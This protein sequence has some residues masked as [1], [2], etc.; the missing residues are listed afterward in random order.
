VEVYQQDGVDLSLNIA[1]LNLKE[2]EWTPYGEKVEKILKEIWETGEVKNYQCLDLNWPA[3][4]KP[5]QNR[6]SVCCDQCHKFIGDEK[7]AWFSDRKKDLDF[8]S[9]GCHS[10]FR[11][12]NDLEKENEGLKE[13]LKKENN[14]KIIWMAISIATFSVFSLMILFCWLKIKKLKK[15]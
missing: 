8:C 5:D 1:P 15:R 3:V 4:S 12:H 6:L 10:K 2:K 13:Q 9:E 7:L 11:K 14:H